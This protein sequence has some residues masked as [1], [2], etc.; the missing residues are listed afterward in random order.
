[1]PTREDAVALLEE[2]VE[3]PGLRT[4][5]YCVEAACRHYARMRGADEELWGLAGLLHDLDWEKHPDDHPLKAALEAGCFY[6]GALGSRKTHA[7]RVDRLAAMGLS[8]EQIDVLPCTV[9]LSRPRSLLTCQRI[10]DFRR[11][12]LGGR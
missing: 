10:G 11:Q 2:W 3:N 7:K 4:H 6:V 8:P 12:G 1:M 9:G 5:M